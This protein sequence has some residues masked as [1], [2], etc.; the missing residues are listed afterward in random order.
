MQNEKK[1]SATFKLF[2][3]LCLLLPALSAGILYLEYLT[4]IEFLLHVAAIPLE[5]LVGGLL[6]ERFLAHKEKDRKRHQLMYIKSYLFRSQMRDL[7]ISNFAALEQPKITMDRIRNSST[8]QLLD[9]R[10][11]LADLRYLSDEAIETVVMEYLK[12]HRVFREFMEWAITNDFE[13]IF[14]D[15]IYLLHFIQDIQLFRAHHPDALFMEHARSDPDLMKKV[16]AILQQGVYS[17]L[18]YVIELK[19]K[20]PDILNDLL[21]DYQATSHMKQTSARPVVHNRRFHDRNPPSFS[22][23]DCNSGR[24][25]RIQ[26]Q[27]CS[28][29]P[30]ASTATCDV[31]NTDPE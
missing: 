10:K 21:A 30:G 5:M 19:E 18:D 23:R 4:H 6:L 24:E 16:Q 14:H 31:H 25:R 8:T 27:N 2:L 29:L 9:I 1:G 20:R 15:M 22:N 7:F 28:P 13:S 11:E 17:F 12:A 3:L 26:G